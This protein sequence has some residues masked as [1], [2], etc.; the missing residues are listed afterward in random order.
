MK[1]VSVFVND[2]YSWPASVKV[3]SH[4]PYGSCAL[5][6]PYNPHGQNV[7]RHTRLTCCA[8]VNSLGIER[9]HALQ[10]IKS[11][12]GNKRLRT[13]HTISMSVVLSK[14]YFC[15][16]NQAAVLAEEDALVA[17]L[18]DQLKQRTPHFPISCNPRSSSAVAKD[19]G[20]GS[21][22]QTSGCLNCPNSESEFKLGASESLVPRDVDDK[23]GDWA[24]MA[25]PETLT[26][27]LEQILLL[28][29][30]CCR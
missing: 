21:N 20:P 28:Q 11:C 1:S 19:F 23:D 2:E 7:G 17:N 18:S 30:W 10:Y 14:W 24:Q 26:E 9:A 25:V 3:K 22:R 6:Q 4:N 15:L 5:L 27:A 13:P 8:F 16:Q 12:H 29:V